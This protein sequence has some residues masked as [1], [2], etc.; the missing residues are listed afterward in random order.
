MTKKTRTRACA[1]TSFAAVLFALAAFMCACSGSNQR[2]AKQANAAPASSTAN[3]SNSDSANEGAAIDP[4][5]FDAE[6]A[7]LEREAERNPSDDDAR[8]ALSQ[9]YVRRGN[10]FR[11]A[12]KPREALLD[13]QRALRN[14]PDNEDAQKNIAEISP[15]VE[16]NP[17]AEN[18]EPAPLPITPN[19]TDEDDQKPTPAKT[20]KKQ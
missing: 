18:G 16:G 12:Q 8:A 5:K 10:A 15:L 4:S 19:V 17:T 14:N 9:A 1:T 3:S 11:D 13:Y 6:I 2:S 7:R 20:P